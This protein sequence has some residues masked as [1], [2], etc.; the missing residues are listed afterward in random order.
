VSDFSL[1]QSDVFEFLHESHHAIRMLCFSDG[2]VVFE[3]HEA[4]Q[5]LFIIKSGEIR[6][7]DW[8]PGGGSRLID[9]LGPDEW[10]GSAALG[11]L[12]S[13]GKRAISVGD[14]VVWAIPSG[15]LRDE[16]MRSGE[17][18]MHFIEIMAR[19]L[20][21]AWSDASRLMFQD[22]RL[23]VIKALLKFSSTPAA[24][25]VPEGVSLRI[26]HAELAE[27]IGAA[28]ETVSLCLTDLR[29]MNVVRTGRNQI[30]FDPEGL[31]QFEVN[32]FPPPPYQEAL[33]Q[34]A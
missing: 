3:P 8:L 34:S 6:F 7:L 23:R 14:T 21:G 27:A 10:F 33:S 5:T 19:Q 13:Y 16:L 12:P 17:L 30:V 11:G 2:Q 26:T 9:I 29:H 24:R 4:A 32:E 1:H 18:A 15:E 22:C 28:R 31:R 25:P 20:Q